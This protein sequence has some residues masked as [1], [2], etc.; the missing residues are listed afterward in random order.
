MKLA[1]EDRKNAEVICDYVV[2]EQTEINIKESTKEGKLK[3]LLWLS[4]FHNHKSYASM[5]KQDVLNH[6]NSLRK[7]INGLVLIMQGK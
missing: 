1:N 2:A 6:L 4:Y 5:T 7:P 3:C